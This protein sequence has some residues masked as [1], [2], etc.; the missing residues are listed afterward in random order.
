MQNF[1][2]KNQELYRIQNTLSKP[3]ILQN[4]EYSKKPGIL[5]NSLSKLGV[6]QNTECS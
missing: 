6:P 1:L 5:Q 2:K 4:T 3:G